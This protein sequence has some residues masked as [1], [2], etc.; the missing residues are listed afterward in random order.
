MAKKSNIDLYMRAKAGQ[1]VFSVAN[2][3]ADAVKMGLYRMGYKVAMK[4]SAKQTTITI[5]EK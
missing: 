3:N 1:R 5:Q 2:A 4:R